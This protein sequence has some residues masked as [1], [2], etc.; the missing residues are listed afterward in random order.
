MI[1]FATTNLSCT[2]RQCNRSCLSSAE[3]Y[4]CNVDIKLI[5]AHVL[6]HLEIDCNITALFVNIRCLINEITC[7]MNKQYSCFH[8]HC[9]YI[10][11]VSILL[12][13]ESVLSQRGRAMLR[14]CIV[15]YKVSECSFLTAHQHKK[16]I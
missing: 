12:I 6:A 13:Q 8:C 9:C 14:V 15:Q 2:A 4:T 10:V 1:T 16:A 7:F 11:P 5:T 3:L